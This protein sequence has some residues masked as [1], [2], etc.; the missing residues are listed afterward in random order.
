MS[1][2]RV[3]ELN[4]GRKIKDCIVDE[5]QRKYW[6][7]ETDLITVSKELRQ[8]KTAKSSKVSRYKT[9]IEQFRQNDL[10]KNN[11][12]RVYDELDGVIETNEMVQ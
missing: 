2:S 11:Q 6:L 4:Q 1:L 12:G 7:K 5:L 8:N 9:R 3:E 10:F